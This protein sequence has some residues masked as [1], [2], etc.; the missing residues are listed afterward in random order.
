M[1]IEPTQTGC[2]AEP[3]KASGVANN[4]PDNVVGKPVG[5]RVRFKGQLFGLCDSWHNEKK[6]EQ[7]HDST[8]NSIPVE[9]TP[10]HADSSARG[11]CKADKFEES[12]CDS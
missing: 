11:E 12:L 6:T 10:A 4:P 5:S 2:G 9:I 8:N 1:T 7:A 3:Q